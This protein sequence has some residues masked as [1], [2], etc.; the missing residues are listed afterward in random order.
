MQGKARNKEETLEVLKEFFMLGCS[1]RKA[2]EYAG[3]PHSTVCTWL[4]KDDVIRTKI[5]AWQNYGNTLARRNWIKK[6]EEGDYNASDK[7]LSKK[8]KDEFS[9]RVEQ[10]GP[11][12]KDLVPT[13]ISIKKPE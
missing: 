10:T 1:I 2:C 4:E 8:E 12:G 13:S 5:T 11:E 9:D 6:L 7:W 3:I